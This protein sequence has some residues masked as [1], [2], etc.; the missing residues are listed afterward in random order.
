MPSPDIHAPR[1]FVAAPLAEGASVAGSPAQ[2]HYLGTVLRLGPGA[3]LRLFNGRD[4]EFAATIAAL[5]RD[6]LTLDVGPL[7]RPQAPEPDIWLVFSPL[8]RDATDMVVQK[9]TEL[10]A[11][12]LLPVFC[13]RTN[14]ARINE[15]RLAAIALEAAEQCERLTIPSLAPP[16]PLADLL[17]GWPRDRVLAAA[18]ERIP[19]LPSARDVD[20][21][22]LLVG[23]EGG[24]TPGELDVMRATPFIRSVSLGPR[25]LR[26]E[27]AALAGLALLLSRTW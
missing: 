20:A 25:I 10:G 26:A 4:G 6:R 16:R 22:A 11:A 2:A 24:F 8:K 9:A 14:T 27:T 18:L 3:G 13:A 7:T 23:P 17:G 19:A 5:R 21:G 12:A 15:A 1:L